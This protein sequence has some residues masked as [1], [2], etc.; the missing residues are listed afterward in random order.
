MSK[1]ILLFALLMVSFMFFGCTQNTGPGTQNTTLT[2]QYGDNVTL[3]Y[4]LTVDG[5]VMDTTNADAA[6]SAGIYNA[7]RSYMPL[8]FQVLLGGNVIPGFANGVLGMKV[9]ES[10][11]F[12]VA[13]ADGYGLKDPAKISS[14]PRYYNISIFEDI[15]IEYVQAQNVTVE[16][17][18]VFATVMGYVGIENYTNDTVTIRY[19]VS[20]GDNFAMF[21]IPQ[22]IVNMTNNTLLVRSDMEANHTYTFIDP[23][24]GKKVPLTVTY[25][26]NDTITTDENGPLAGKELHFVV[27]MRAITRN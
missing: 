20:P 26:D 2:V 14:T 3:D 10:K 18:R 5:Q 12:T 4:T 16:K 24:T 25:A 21:G 6:K 7:N 22:T 9:G 19:I 27:M 15:P 1:Y 23:N 17:G 11:N 13:P 8:T